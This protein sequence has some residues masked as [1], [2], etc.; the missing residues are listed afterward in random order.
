MT[1]EERQE[2]LDVKN[3]G[4]L[5]T[6]NFLEPMSFEYKP[7]DYL[8]NLKSGDYVAKS[9]YEARV[10]LSCL[11]NFARE[12]GSDAPN[13]CEGC[14]KSVKNKPPLPEYNPNK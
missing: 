6:P 1:N 4:Y 11:R 12:A 7:V 13:K 5:P 14:L 10:C 3:L 8:E 2:T 9:S